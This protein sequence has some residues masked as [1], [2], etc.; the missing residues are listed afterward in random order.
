MF[1]QNPILGALAIF[2]VRALSIALST[3]RYLI[4]GRAKKSLVALIALFES[5]AFVLTFGQVAQDL[6]NIWNLSGYCLGF[7]AGTI[8]GIWLEE[9]MVKGYTTVNIISRGKSLPIVEAI[10]EAGFGAT[11]SAG[12]GTGGSVGLVRSVV[13]RQMTPSI[14]DIA[15]K[16]DEEAFVTI[17]D[18][19]QV[20]RGFM[21]YGRS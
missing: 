14:V 21:G 20:R 1:F 6:N 4:M 7:A 17:E 10:H 19:R 5:L 3:V 16:I 2:V 18:I 12:E 15:T 13:P 8:V 11:R 9:R